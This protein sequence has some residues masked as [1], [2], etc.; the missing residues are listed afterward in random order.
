MISKRVWVGALLAAV[1]GSLPAEAAVELRQLRD[2]DYQAELEL[3]SRQGAGD[4]DVLFGNDLIKGVVIAADRPEKGL[5]A[6]D[7]LLL[8]SGVD[9]PDAIVRFSPA[10]AGWGKPEVGK[11]ANVAVLRFHHAGGKWNAELTYQ[12]RET[13]P[14]IEVSTTVR[15]T[16]SGQTLEVPIVD[17]IVH[18]SKNGTK[19]EWGALVAASDDGKY[20]AALLPP[21]NQ[22]RAR[23]TGK[24]LWIGY[25]AND[26]EPGMLKRV[27]LRLLR[28]KNPGI[29]TF[30]PV[31]PDRAWPRDLRVDDGWHR[32]SPGEERTIKRRLLSASSTEEMKTLVEFSKD[33]AAPVAVAGQAPQPADKGEK[34]D[35]IV[36]TL[37]IRPADAPSE[38]ATPKTARFPK[39]PPATP[40]SIKVEKKKEAAIKALD[41]TTDEARSAPSLPPLKIEGVDKQPPLPTPAL[42][43]IQS[44][45]PPIE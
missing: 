9:R 30:Q 39:L 25:V 13:T 42:P 16:V 6:G 19:R 4:G 22:I 45:P 31:G 35:K 3:A 28:S 32:L 14:F 41:P 24:D 2:G 29:H 26:P 36:G 21:S 15:N 12:V 40:A 43:D 20:Q 8:P 5:L 23:Q 18:P 1:L 10:L 38:P 11:N 44:L 7:L 37:R 33:D 17:R 34:K 27:G